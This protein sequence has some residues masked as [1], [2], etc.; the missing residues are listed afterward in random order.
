M[1]AKSVAQRRL[2]AIALHTPSSVSKKNRGVLKM[3]ES[4]MNDFAHTKEK[5]LKVHVINMIKQGRLKRK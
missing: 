2:M 3:S 5:G 4:D 1:P